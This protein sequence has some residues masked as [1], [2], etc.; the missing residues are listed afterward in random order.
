[1]YISSR[2]LLNITGVFHILIGI[3]LFFPIVSKLI[4]NGLINSV[5]YAAF[6]DM[7]ILFFF[8]IGFML[9]V[10]SEA[11]HYI[12]KIRVIPEY[13]GWMIMLITLFTSLMMPQSGFWIGIPQGILII[14]RA[15]KYKKSLI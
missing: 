8:N 14:Y 15:K 11:F 6:D 13:I 12:E 2:L 5:S 3:W 10:L 7:A 1:M 9:I 4:K